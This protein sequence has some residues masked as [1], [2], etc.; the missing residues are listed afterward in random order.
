VAYFARAAAC[1]RVLGMLHA[2]GISTA[3]PLA[4]RQ[5]LVVPT[6]ETYD[7]GT[8]EPAR[9]IALL[10]GAIDAALAD[11]YSG[12][13]ATGEQ[14]STR[15]PPRED[16]LIEYETM[17]GELFRARSAV[18]LCQYDA[19]RCDP[20]LLETMRDLHGHV[21]RNAL[22]SANKLLRIVP[23]ADDQHGD[24]WLKVIGE[25]DLSS[26]TLLQAGLDELGHGD[27]HLDLGRL[28]FVDLRGVDA[29]R[30]LADALRPLQRRLILHNPPAMLRRIVE[31]APGCLPHVE[32]SAR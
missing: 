3:E 6:D 9:R 22:V 24:S 12:F 19:T 26:S 23:L 11:G 15:E 1:E 7:D 30:G 25:A 18:A 8:F 20:H 29:L 21:V 27:L 17:V 2:G 4:Q 5:L 28:Q 31:L 32:I 16:L 14:W 13:R 10:R